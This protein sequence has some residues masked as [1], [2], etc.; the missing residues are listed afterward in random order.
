[1]EAFNPI[2]LSAKRGEKQTGVGVSKKVFSSSCPTLRGLLSVF[3]RRGLLLSPSLLLPGLLWFRIGFGQRDWRRC[4]GVGVGEA[5][6]ASAEARPE[7]KNAKEV[8]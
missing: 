2:R 6:K 1:L 3:P 7:G 5:E 4:G 8:V